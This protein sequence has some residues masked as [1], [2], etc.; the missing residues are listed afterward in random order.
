MFLLKKLSE[1]QVGSPGEL[2]IPLPIPRCSGWL[3][4]QICPSHVTVVTS[5]VV[6]DSSELCD[7]PCGVIIGTREA[8][9]VML[10]TQALPETRRAAV[11][12]YPLLERTIPVCGCKGQLIK[13]AACKTKITTAM[14]V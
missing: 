13:Q 4:W 2:P 1:Q 7:Q 10:A 14:S 5:V 3:L 11:M 12:S 9:R 6:A 8:G